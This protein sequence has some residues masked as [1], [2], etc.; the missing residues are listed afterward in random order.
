M[1]VLAGVA[2]LLIGAPPAWSQKSADKASENRKGFR[3]SVLAVRGQIDTTLGA[4]DKIG[5]GKDAKERKA[6][7]KKYSSEVK[8]MGGQVEKTRDYAQKMKEQGKAYFKQW[9]KSMKGVTNPELKASGEANRAALQAQYDKIEKGIA[10]AK[11]DSARFWQNV[12][13]LE[14]FYVSDLSDSAISTSAKLVETTNADGKKIQGYIDEVVKAVDEVGTVTEKPA[15]AAPDAAKPE[16]GTP[17]GTKP[18]EGAPAEDTPVEPPPPGE[19]APTPP[20]A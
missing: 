2:A 7:L 3:E 19:S 20:P 14:K 17:E 16:E 13:D 15:E 5:K 18:E 8:K 4:L 9:E 12:Q 1:V 11:E 6:A 10:Q